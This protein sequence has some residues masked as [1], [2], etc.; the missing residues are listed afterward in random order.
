MPESIGS[1]TGGVADFLDISV[2]F[3]LYHCAAAALK[4][5]FTR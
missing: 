2:T 5:G 4:G 1:E 3:G